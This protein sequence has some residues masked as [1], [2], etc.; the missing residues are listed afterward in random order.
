MR[1]RVYDKQS[2]SYFIS[3]VYA[4]INTGYYEK[5]LILESK[6]DARYFRLVEYLYK[7]NSNLPVNVNLISSNDLT[8]WIFKE[9]ND[10]KDINSRL[11]AKDKND[12]FYSYRGYNFIFKQENLLITLLKGEQ[13]DYE[14]MCGREKEVST[15]LDSWIYIESENDI[16]NLMEIFHGFHDSVLRNLNYI[17]GSGKRD[18]GIIVSDS[19]RQVSMIFDSL[20]SESIEIVFEG[21]L[22]LNLRPAQDKYSSDL[23]SATILIKDSAILFYDDKV[24]Y[25]QKSYE[26]T[27]INALGMRWRFLLD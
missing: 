14:S 12:S 13:V 16:H 7:S 11:D 23:S 22:L 21:V 20:W 10:L 8:E 15:K 1:V 4:I 19:I 26:G 5:Y 27:W 6:N 3:E 25:E 9:E 2:N 18:K 24:D 17:S